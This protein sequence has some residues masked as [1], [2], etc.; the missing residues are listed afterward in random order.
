MGQ[1]CCTVS[2]SALWALARFTGMI[3]GFKNCVGIKDDKQA[4]G[5]YELSGYPLMPVSLSP[6]EKKPTKIIYTQTSLDE[7]RSQ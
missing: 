7:H 1:P 2:L 3:G 4:K 6:S 5:S